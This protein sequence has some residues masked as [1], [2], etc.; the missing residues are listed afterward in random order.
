MIVLPAEGTLESLVGDQ[1]PSALVQDIRRGCR[2]IPDR[3]LHSTEIIPES[4][5]SHLLQKI[6][7]L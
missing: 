7:F 5:E 1:D 3:G 2:N 4:T 6:L